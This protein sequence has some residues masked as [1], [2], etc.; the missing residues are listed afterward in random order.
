MT[1]HPKDDEA[2]IEVDGQE[3]GLIALADFLR[4]LH[5]KWK[6]HPG[7]IKLGWALFYGGFKDIFGQ[8]GRN[9]GKT[10]FIAYAATRY[11]G[12]RPKSENY[13]FGPIQKQVK[14][15]LWASQRIQSMPPEEFVQNTNNV[16]MRVTLS[17]EAFIKLDGSD[18]V[19]SYRGI[20]PK[21]LSVY[22]EFKDMKKEFVDA[23]DPNRAA[24]DSPAIYIGTPPEFH[25]H[26]VE[27]AETAKKYH[28]TDWFFLH[29]PSSSN[30]HI[31][32]SWLERK[33]RQ[34]IEAG[35]LETWQ[36]EYEAIYIKGGKR[37]IFPQFL[38]HLCR[39]IDELTPKDL[40]KW[41]L[42]THFDPA[43]TSVFGVLFSLFNPYTKRLILVDEIYE[44]VMARMTTRQ[45]WAQ[46]MPIIE[47]W[48]EKGIRK[49]EYGYDEA[50]AWFSNETTDWLSDRRE[51]GEKVPPD[52][53]LTPT[54]KN[55]YGIET[56]IGMVRDIFNHNLI[57]VSQH[58][59]K[60]RFEMENYIKTEDGKIPK[61]GDHQINNLQYTLQLLGYEFGEEKPPKAQDPDDMPRGK[62]LEEDLADEIG[63]YAEIGSDYM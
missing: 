61:D 35:D 34:L 6:P 27:T 18:N 42:V 7:Q 39:P 14:E 60:T 25:N 32:K 58:L 46:V 49:F 29:A 50:A 45:I 11:A 63:E 21:G 16:E 40:N 10:E 57:E 22:D 47:K 23:Y 59:E 3:A 24:F 44:D 30:P 55:E 43:T 17:N 52:L 56:G 4:Q 51:K 5:A 1:Y 15:I 62:S 41:W 20:K 38:K 9:F 37:H 31:A 13:I 36:R 2:L 28:G 12:E 8:C 33:K 26:F 19:D 54:K 53:W 48:C